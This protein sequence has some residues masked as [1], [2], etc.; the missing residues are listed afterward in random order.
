M[1]AP[2]IKVL[3]IVVY[4]DAFIWIVGVV[5]TLYY[6]FTHRDL[7]TLGGIRLLGGPYEKL[8]LDSLIVAGI[9]KYFRQI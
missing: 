8:G 1:H 3:T 2:L 7:P 6:A 5:L 9:K 4:I